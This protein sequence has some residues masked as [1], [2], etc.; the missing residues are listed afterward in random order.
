MK[1]Q[2]LRFLATVAQSDLNITTAATKLYTTQPAVSKQLR[3]LE[4]EL[5]FKIFV[6][7]GR[8]L[9][10][11]TPPGERVIDC[12][13]RVLRE[14]H[15]IKGISTDFRD[16]S[17][18]TL[19]IG[20][21]HTQARYV[22]PPVIKEFRER[23]PKVQF[24]L[25]QGTSEQIAEMAQNGR[26]DLA[27]ATGSS[28][29][30]E[31]FVLLPC[32]RWHRQVIVPHG[33]PLTELEGPLTMEALGAHPIVSYV[34]SFT[35]PSSLTD[36]FLARNLRP[37]IALAAR[38]A[39]V[40]KTYVRLG[41]GVGIIANMAIDPVEDADLAV[42]E[43]SHLF[44]THTTWVGFDRSALLRKYM[45]DFVALLAPQLTRRVVDRAR[46]VASQAETDALFDL[47][48]LPVR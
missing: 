3:Q 27:I 42:I 17:A 36:A 47:K 46:N 25:L 38:D 18:G 30:F 33:H 14:I 10:K 15:N 6:R 16:D 37:N 29:Q 20:T 26:I 39:D 32:Y 23:Y 12:A 21:T 31:K 4:D 41:I 7:H 9:S 28:A 43:A 44:P 48:E 19:S 40:I 35:G 11:I 1:L 8:A 22:L 45:Y 13:V 34:F 24:N 2:Q 5:G